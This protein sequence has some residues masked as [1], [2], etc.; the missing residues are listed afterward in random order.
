MNEHDGISTRTAL[1]GLL[2]FAVS[3]VCIVAVVFYFFL[4]GNTDG[5]PRTPVVQF[6]IPPIAI[7]VFITLFS[8]LVVGGAWRSAPAGLG[9]I[10]A[11]PYLLLTVSQSSFGGVAVVF[12]VALFV[13][14]AHFGASHLLNAPKKSNVA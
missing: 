7:F 12:G 5:T 1:L 2:T 9:C 14:L 8:A 6:F 3:I 10:A 13:F 11:L 4:F